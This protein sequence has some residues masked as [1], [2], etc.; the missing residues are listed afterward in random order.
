M[1]TYDYDYYAKKSGL[2]VNEFSIKHSENSCDNLHKIASLENRAPYTLFLSTKIKK[3]SCQI[4]LFN[5]NWIIIL[6][7]QIQE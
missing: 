2:K 7:S 3:C 1:F 6:Y 4:N 5:G